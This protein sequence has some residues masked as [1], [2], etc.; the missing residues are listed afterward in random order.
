VV[1]ESVEKVEGRILPM[2]VHRFLLGVL[3]G[4]GASEVSFGLSMSAVVSSLREEC[5][6]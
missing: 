3:D 4:E 6:L 1:G 2:K 5:R